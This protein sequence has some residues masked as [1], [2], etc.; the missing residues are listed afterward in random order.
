MPSMSRATSS[1]RVRNG[2]PATSI[3]TLGT[4]MLRG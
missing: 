2:L 3:I 4:L 1:W